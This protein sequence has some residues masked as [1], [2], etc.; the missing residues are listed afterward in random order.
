MEN[1]LRGF[2]FF[3]VLRI[4]NL[5]SSELKINAYLEHSLGAEMVRNIRSSTLQNSGIIPVSDNTNTHTRAYIYFEIKLFFKVLTYNLCKSRL[6]EIWKKTQRVMYVKGEL[7]DYKRGFTDIERRKEGREIYNVSH[8]INIYMFERLLCQALKKEKI[9]HDRQTIFYEVKM[10]Y[11][12]AIVKWEE[13]G[14]RYKW[15]WMVFFLSSAFTA[16]V[17]LCNM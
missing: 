13:R 11:G 14:V 17:G 2:C 15:I 1:L 10:P 16:I 7:W 3:S 6:S 9:K 12:Y 4:T 5:Y 8:H